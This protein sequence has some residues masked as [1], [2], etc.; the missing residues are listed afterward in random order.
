[1]RRPTANRGADVRKQ[2][3]S[4][5]PAARSCSRND[6]THSLN[7]CIELRDRCEAPFVAQNG[8]RLHF[9]RLPHHPEHDHRPAAA[10]DPERPS[11]HFARLAISPSDPLCVR[12]SSS[13]SSDPTEPLQLPRYCV[14]LV[15]V[16]RLDLSIARPEAA[17]K[18]WSH[19]SRRLGAIAA[20]H[21]RSSAPVGP[22][23]CLS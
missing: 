1:M 7:C 12:F 16:P 23:R 15:P 22:V 17:H 13:S 3:T 14:P 10:P 21:H 8:A 6:E 18:L 19:P 2:R 4:D 9:H 11:H 20:T 5:A